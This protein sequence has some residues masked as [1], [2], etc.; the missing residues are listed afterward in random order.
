[1]QFTSGSCRTVMAYKEG[2]VFWAME[3]GCAFC[4]DSIEELKDQMAEV[5]RGPYAIAWVVLDG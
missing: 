4:A 3:N 2:G 1:M 5:L